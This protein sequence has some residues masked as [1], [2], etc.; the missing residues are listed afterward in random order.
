[1]PR[2]RSLD[3]PR[4][5]RQFVRNL[6]EGIYITN[7]D[8]DLIDA[9]PAMLEIF[10][11][12]TLEA[13]RG[14]TAPELYVDP[15]ERERKLEILAREGAVREFEFQVKRPDGGVRTLI[16]TCYVVEDED[17]GEPTYHGILVDITRRKELEERLREYS[18][19]DPLTGC[20]NRRYL[21]QA[22]ERL[23]HE[24]ST[25]GAVV[26]D[27]DHFKEYNDR[28]G[29]QAG[30]DVLVKVSRFLMRH[31][32]AEDPV[33]RIGGDEFLALLLGT[34]GN[35]TA[36]AAQRIHSVVQGEAPVP[37]SFGWALRE[38]DETLQQTIGRADRGLIRVR[39]EERGEQRW[40]VIRRRQAVE[41]P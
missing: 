11:V 8:G 40:E 15:G 3:D 12:E 33:V 14:Y 38:G 10:G 27:V 20:Y 19:R 35:F 13:L 1:M 7:R 2:H 9:N 32:R 41:Q 22:Q 4:T 39:L 31:V 6:R 17:S 29:H 5:L 21:K 37:L 28:N 16:D 23:A 18:L 34:G 36:D 30:D 24:G 26:V 25:W